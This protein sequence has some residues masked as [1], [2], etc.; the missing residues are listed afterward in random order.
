MT[1]KYPAS[2]SPLLLAGNVVIDSISVLVVLRCGS[3][4]IQL[5][6]QRS[7]PGLG[8]AGEGWPAGP[9]SPPSAH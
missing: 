3:P 4:Q 8:D 2:I 6:Q 7:R 9:S 5:M 1:I